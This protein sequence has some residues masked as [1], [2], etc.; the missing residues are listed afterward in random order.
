MI[1][2]KNPLETLPAIAL[3]P[4]NF[5]V[6]LSAK[7]Y[8]RQ[9]IDLIR[10]AKCRIYLVAL[11]LEDD[12]AGRE[13]MTELYAAKQR[14]PLLDISVCV[15]WHRAQR[16]LIG[17]EKSNGNAEMYQRF[18]EQHAEKI[19]VYG[20]PVRNREIFGVL[21]LKGFIIDDSVIY[22]GASLN[23]VY[24]HHAE[25]YRFDRYHTIDNKVLADSM[26]SLIQQRIIS[27]KAVY[28]LCDPTRPTTKELK[29]TIKRFRGQ[30][31]RSEYSYE[32]QKI[33]EGQVG[34]T[35][36]VGVGKRR[37]RLNQRIYQLIGQA[38]EELIIC[39]P[40]FNF[41]ARISNQVKRALRRGVKVSIIVGDKT[42]NDFYIPPDK[43]FKTISGLPYLYELNL[44][45]FAKAYEARIASRQLSIHLWKHDNNS[46]HLKGIWVDQHYMLLTGNNLNPRA[47]KLDLENGLLINDKQ[48]HLLEK[49]QQEF[50]NI[51]QHTQLIG[52]YKQID[53]FD[54]YPPL[55]L[56]LLRRIRRTK[57]DSILKQ[58]L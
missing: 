56:K 12:E 30:L 35:P 3:D 21:H 44:R 27:H 52:S 2:R 46:F 50:D 40:Y 29:P 31:R 5:H 53:P 25:R 48:G 18:A 33:S 26:V 23:N 55:V 9:L 39:T 14:N 22:S 19:P 41:P 13:I 20:I 36:L 57:T 58:I 38:K 42:A 15:D 37:N 16:G 17:A 54:S 43:P 49:F 47:W 45:R 4:Q 10:Q 34:I 51:T 7:A 24:L 28:N 11:Y 6:L 8:K 1:G 32:P